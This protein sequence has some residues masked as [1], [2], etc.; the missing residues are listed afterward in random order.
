MDSTTA[1]STTIG[2]YA[3][4]LDDPQMAIA[5]SR[6]KALKSSCDEAGT[7]LKELQDRFARTE[8]L[9]EMPR[10][11]L[12][13]AVPNLYADT[14]VYAEK[15]S[16]HLKN[17]AMMA[18][19]FAGAVATAIVGGIVPAMMV[20]GAVAAGSFLGGVVVTRP[21]FDISKRWIIPHQT[22]K[23]LK[24]RIHNEQLFLEGDIRMAKTIYDDAQERYLTG[25]ML[26]D[27]KAADALKRISE[28]PPR[29]TVDESVPGFVIIDGIRLEKRA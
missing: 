22:E 14:K 15:D 4:A 19:W 3:R 11:K 21:L 24:N 28:P 18:T 26:V 7:H 9:Q 10:E 8:K 1:A 27:E 16:E 6:L 23:F 2:E 13:E 20:K 25:K 17:M 29:T 12:F 5:M